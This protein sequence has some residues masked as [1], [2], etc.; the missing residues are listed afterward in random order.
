MMV[1][2]GTPA[3][4]IAIAAPLR[5]EW[6]PNRFG[7][8]P[9]LPSPIEVAASLRHLRSCG[10]VNWSLDPSLCKNVFTVVSVLVDG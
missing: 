7:W 8:K 1:K 9:S 3:R 10:P 4:Y 2:T 6:R 5:A